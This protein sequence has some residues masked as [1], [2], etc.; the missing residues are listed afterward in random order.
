[1]NNLNPHYEQG[2]IRHIFVNNVSWDVKVIGGCIFVVWALGEFIALKFL[3]R[4]ALD[5]AQLECKSVEQGE[6]SN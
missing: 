5:Q 3:C 2:Q 6:V 4:V 1:M